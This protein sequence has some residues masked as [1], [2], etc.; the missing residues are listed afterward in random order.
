MNGQG[1]QKHAGALKYI[2]HCTYKVSPVQAN[3]N[4]LVSQSTTS[5]LVP[6]PNS[7]TQHRRFCSMG[8]DKETGTASI[9]ASNVLSVDVHCPALSSRGGLFG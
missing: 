7:N 2:S 1:I 3:S 5:S 4:A 9:H 6:D 8:F